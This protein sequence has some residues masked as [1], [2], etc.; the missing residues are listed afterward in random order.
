[1]ELIGSPL[2]LNQSVV[3]YYKKNGLRLQM[4]FAL[5][6]LATCQ[7]QLWIQDGRS[8]TWKNFISAMRSCESAARA[9]NIGRYS[10][11]LRR[12]TRN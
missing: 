5:Q 8:P 2:K 3:K 10:D 11:N 4:A 12:N 9:F 1:M 6:N 7:E